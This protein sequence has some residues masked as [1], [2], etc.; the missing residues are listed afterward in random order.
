MLHLI[1]HA[2]SEMNL[3][4]RQAYDQG[5][6]YSQ[7]GVLWDLRLVDPAITSQGRQEVHTAREL[8]MPLRLDRVYVSPLLRAL[9]TCE[10]LLE[11]HSCAPEVVVL[12][13]ATEIVSDAGDISKGNW[14]HRSLFPQFDWSRMHEQNPVYWL[15]SVSDSPFLQSTVASSQTAEEIIEKLCRELQRKH[16]NYLET[17]PEAKRRVLFLH[18]VLQADLA[19]GLNV[20]LVAHGDILRALMKTFRPVAEACYLTNC[21]IWSIDSSAAGIGGLET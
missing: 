19:A 7:T 1:R 12:P 13:Q 21:Q 3:S 4:K 11:A 14:V 15:A 6:L 16:P 9:Q 20:A 17:K 18:S 5:L 10:G 8:V 2:E